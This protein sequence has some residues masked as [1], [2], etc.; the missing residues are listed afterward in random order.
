[1][2]KMYGS[3]VSTMMCFEVGLHHSL[4]ICLILIRDSN[5][6]SNPLQLLPISLI[7]VLYAFQRCAK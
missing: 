2:Q 7:R 6:N 1:M 4:F 5:S 3:T